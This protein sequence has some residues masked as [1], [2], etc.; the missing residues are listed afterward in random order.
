MEVCGLV[1]GQKYSR[2]LGPLQVAEMIKTTCV[3]P[4]ER[5]KAIEA[6]YKGFEFANNEYIKAWGVEVASK[7]IQ[8]KGRTLPPPKLEYHAS[9]SGAIF[10]PRAGVW[11]MRGK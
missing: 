4:A 1:P 11:D 10:E 9:S 8:V 3:K 6:G 5:L 7:P 2:K